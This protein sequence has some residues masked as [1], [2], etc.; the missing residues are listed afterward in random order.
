MRSIDWPCGWKTEGGS[1]TGRSAGAA[2]HWVQRFS[3]FSPFLSRAR[4]TCSK[5]DEE[6]P[7][8]KTNRVIRLR[9]ALRM[10]NSKG[11]GRWNHEPP[12]LKPKRDRGNYSLPASGVDSPRQIFRASVLGI[13]V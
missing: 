5:N 11:P 3:K 13:S 7:P 9:R 8:R 4:V 2:A 12:R 6:N 1:T 10:A